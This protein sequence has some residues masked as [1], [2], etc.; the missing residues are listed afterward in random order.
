LAL[1]PENVGGVG[2]RVGL[3]VATNYVLFRAFDLSLSPMTALLLFAV[4]QIGGAPAATPGNLG[5]FH[6]PAVLVL[7]A[8]AVVLHAVALRPKIIAGVIIIG[9]TRT[10]LVEPAWTALAAP[11]ESAAVHRVWGGRV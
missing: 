10:P 7:V 6:Y 8:Y 9:A 2:S 1:E 5:V 4:L 3:A 11:G